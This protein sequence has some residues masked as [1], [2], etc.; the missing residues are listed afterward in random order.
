[1]PREYKIQF[2][3]PY[4]EL[5]EIG[6]FRRR[7]FSKSDLEHSPFDAGGNVWLEPNTGTMFLRPVATDPKM[8]NEKWDKYVL[9]LTS[10]AYAKDTTGKR[11]LWSDTRFRAL[12]HTW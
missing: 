1:M 5:E 11:N 3:M 7:L 2:D 6:F 10:F 8:H 9:P 12:F 4:T